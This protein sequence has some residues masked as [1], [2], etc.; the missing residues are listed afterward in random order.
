MKKLLATL[1][2]SLGLLLGAAPASATIIVTFTPSAQHVN[3]GDTVSVDVSI[4][5]LAAEILAAFDLNFFYNGAI[6]GSARSADATSAFDQLGGAYGFPPLFVFDVISLGEWGLQ[7]SA[8][9]DDATVAANQADS[10]LLA[11]FTFRADADGVSIFN[12]GPD[13]DFQRNFVGLDALSLQ[14]DVGS[15][16]IAVGTG[17]CQPAPE[18]SSLALIGLALVSAFAFA[19]RRRENF[20]KA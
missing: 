10:F 18:P 3:V 17:V 13:L 19:R 20:A 1:G 12:L 9:A 6:L 4:S 8:L 7:G 16:C 14:V 2:V 11:H 15:A 5:G